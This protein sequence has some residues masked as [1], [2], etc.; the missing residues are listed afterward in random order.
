MT[1]T[2]LDTHIG[3][4]AQVEFN[5]GSQL[6]SAQIRTGDSNP[7]KDGTDE[8]EGFEFDSSSTN[9]NISISK[10]LLLLLQAL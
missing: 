10:A 1:S 4:Q 2:P 5:S 7:I 3:G 6:A 9:P 8:N